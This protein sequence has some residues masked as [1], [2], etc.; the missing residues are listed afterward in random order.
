MQRRM[1]RQLEI[2]HCKVEVLLTAWEY[3]A[4]AIMRKAARRKDAAVLQMLQDIAMLDSYPAVKHHLLTRYV[5]KCR[6]LHS[7]AFL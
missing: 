4:A 2:R 5:N 3:V 1:R 6:E 7:I